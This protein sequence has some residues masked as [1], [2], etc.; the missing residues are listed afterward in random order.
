MDVLIPNL[1]DI[2]EV[3]VIEIT[4][5]P[6]DQL[7]KNDSLIVIESDKASMEV[8]CPSDGVVEEIL[9]TV[10]DMVGEGH[11]VAKIRELDVTNS[12]QSD[13]QELPD[14]SGEESVTNDIASPNRIDFLIPDLGNTSRATVKELLC[15]PGQKV[16]AGSKL[17]LLEADE[18]ELEITSE[19]D[20]VLVDVCL[21][22]NQLVSSGDLV[23]QMESDAVLEENQPIDKAIAPADQESSDDKEVILPNAASVYAGPAVRRL[24]REY[25]V[26]LQEISGSGKRGRIT[27][28]DL[29]AHVKNRLSNVTKS[30]FN[31]GLPEVETINFSKF[32]ETSSLALSRIQQVAA[33]NLHASW[34]NL[35]HVTQHDKVDVT[36][37]EDFRSVLNAEVEDAGGKITPLA[38]ILRASCLVLQDY[39]IFNSSLESS[40][41]SVLVN[42]F[43]NIGF[44]VDTPEG[45][46][47][48]VIKEADKKGL[49]QISSEISDLSEKAREKKLGMNDLQGGTFTISSLGALGGT[50]FTPIVNAPQVAIL[51]VARMDIEPVWT[52]DQFSPR[53]ILPLSLSY[54]HRV[55]NGADG[56]RFMNSLTRL[57][58]DIRR[59]SL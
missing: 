39:P 30:T 22:E 2:D 13:L 43:F 3:E 38:F 53:K 14:I 42:Q 31:Q 52:G 32:G 20:G 8:P 11:L 37:L 9:V 41:T 23:A 7:Q 19:F 35:P 4:V 17:I 54:D 40:G 26:T 1:G 46:V 18:E 29:K 27:K 24:A 16:T 12:E 10:G 34:V 50:G 49:R 56:G 45:L 5:S 48:P 33:K 44:A 15:K 6:G 21:S 59:L 36:D 55:I 47:V 51:G 57:L 28:D 25:G 58:G